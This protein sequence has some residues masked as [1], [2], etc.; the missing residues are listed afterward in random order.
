MPHINIEDLSREI[1]IPAKYETFEAQVLTITIPRKECL[2]PYMICGG[3]VET[4]R[5][6]LS[7]HY[8]IEFVEP[9]Y[10]GKPT[11]IIHEEKPKDGQA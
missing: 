2:S 10:G 4:R 5:V 11:L 3:Q 8:R 7:G 6:A 9:V 1:E